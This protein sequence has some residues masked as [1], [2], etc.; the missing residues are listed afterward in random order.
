[1]PRVQEY[2]D[3]DLADAASR[4]KNLSP[5]QLEIVHGMACGMS[6]KEIAFYLDATMSGVRSQAQSI[7]QI[8]HVNSRSQAGI[9]Y[10]A[11]QFDEETRKRLMNG[12][13]GVDGA[14]IHRA[15]IALGDVTYRDKQNKDRLIAHNYPRLRWLAEVALRA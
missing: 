12:G 3:V 13:R 9:A 1:M 8:L 11:A 5:R 4:I 15:T 10:L 14:R 2:D 7:Y 6:N